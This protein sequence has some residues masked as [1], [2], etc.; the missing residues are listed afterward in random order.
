MLRL[1]GRVREARDA[2]R[3]Q[4]DVIRGVAGGYEGWGVEED[5]EG[6]RKMGGWV[7]GEEGGVGEGGEEGWAGGGWDGV[8]E[9]VEKEEG[10][11]EVK[12]R[13]IRGE[14]L[15]PMCRARGS[16]GQ[17]EYILAEEAWKRGDRAEAAEGVG[18]AVWELEEGRRIAAR[19]RKVEWS[20]VTSSH[21]TTTREREAKGWE[22][23]AYG[24]LAL[25]YLLQAEMAPDAAQREK[26]LKEAAATAKYGVDMAVF[27]GNSILPVLL[28]CYGRVL[29]RQGNKELA[30]EQ[31]NP[32]AFHRRYGVTAP[33]MAMCKEPSPEHRGYLREMVDA[34]ADLDVLDAEGYT[35]L[36][37][38]VFGGDTETEA[39]VLEGLRA[40]LR[41]SESDV[42]TRRTE[43]RLRKGY[44]EVLQEKLRPS[45]YGRDNN[46]KD[47][48]KNLRKVYAETLA[49]DPEKSS[50][51]DHLKYIRYT[52]FKRF[53]RL[54]R[55][56]DGLVRPYQVE[57]SGEDENDLEFLIF[58]SYRWIN[59]DRG[60]N[61]PDDANGTQYRRML[62]AIDLFLQKDPEV[63]VEK[64]GIW[65]VCL[66]GT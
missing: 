44:R 2:F 23:M 56:S 34:G 58:F 22:A 9:G 62:H 40:Q 53:G 55:S 51:F 25:C 6:V 61:T 37:H 13:R 57:Q 11:C 3:G 36:D 60:L 29:L 1:M 30:L 38:A 10:D 16:L 45:L 43:A 12:L 4:V 28:Y 5:G 26:L 20:R 63:D 19:I 17:V 18:T 66:R 8:G 59:Q 21:G 41:L 15:G 7:R 14:M 49:A 32:H 33:V 52:D 64:L 54:P 50:Q 31:F 35:A 48:V 39:I 46:D 24:R 65:M 47:Y 42:V 27:L